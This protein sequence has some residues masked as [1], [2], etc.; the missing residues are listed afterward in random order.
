DPN[1]TYA[2]EQV[3]VEYFVPTDVIQLPWVLIH[4]GTLT[5]TTWGTTP[6]GRDG[7]VHH[8]LQHRRGVYVVDTVERGRA[9]WCSLPGVWQGDP[10]MRSE[11]EA[12][13]LYRLGL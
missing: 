11:E 4:G 9:G 3:Y 6:D 1:G 5:G 2:I 8:L 10:L 13:R 12:W 7:W